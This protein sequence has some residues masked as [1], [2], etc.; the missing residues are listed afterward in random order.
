MHRH[1]HTK[2]Q[3]LVGEKRSVA[4]ERGI[5]IELEQREAIARHLVG[6]VARGGDGRSGE[7]L[8]AHSLPNAQ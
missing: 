1:R 6:G 7:G 8:A 2:T 3:D 4:R 5:P